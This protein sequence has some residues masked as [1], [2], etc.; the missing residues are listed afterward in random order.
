[1]GRN[2]GIDINRMHV[3]AEWQSTQ[4][5]LDERGGSQIISNKWTNL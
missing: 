2:V 1:M 4:F 3:R 5:P